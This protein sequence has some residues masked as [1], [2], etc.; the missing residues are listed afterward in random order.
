MNVLFSSRTDYALLLPKLKSE[1]YDSYHV[2]VNK[3][4]KQIVE[5]LG[6]QVLACFEEEFDQL[7]EAII[8]SSFLQSSYYGD[9]ALWVLDI[10]ER[11][12]VLAKTIAF[13]RKIFNT[14][15]FDLVVHE[16]IAIEF[17]EIMYLI[18][19]ENNVKV[20]SFLSSPF[21]GT[22]FWKESSYHCAFSK[23]YLSQIEIKPAAKDIVLNF[24][25]SVKQK[26]VNPEYLRN[27]LKRNK[28]GLLK[29]GLSLLKLSIKN[30]LG[31]MKNYTHEEIKH[32]AIFNHGHAGKHADHY[33][34]L[35]DRYH[36]SKIEYDNIEKYNDCFRAF[37]PLHY[38]PEA[39]LLYFDP[40]LS[41][42]VSV[43]Q[44]LLKEMPSDAVLF[45]KEHP[46]QPG[47]LMRPE[48]IELRRRNSN[49]KYIP[50]EYDSM[51]VLSQMQILIT[52][53]GT[54]GLESLIKQI[55]VIV[56]GRIFYDEHPDV[57]NVNSFAEVG[58]ILNKKEFNTIKEEN[59]IEYLEKIY[60]IVYKG[61]PNYD[62]KYDDPDNIRDL[63]HSI[64]Q[65]LGLTI[66]ENT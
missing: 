10:Q 52:I 50:A 9:R 2:V 64:E 3:K 30:S 26:G 29:T 42:Q 28:T 66:E 43:I 7:E 5:S 20:G 22:F 23:E 8:P 1:K 39:T 4:E 35:L 37:F 48:Y 49:L 38:E 33:Q 32:D 53:C 45:V 47:Y 16:T 54:F 58:D 27:K 44:Q 65:Y 60:S 57:Y 46:Q 61:D 13:W 56:L 36:T 40:N 62:W 11:K 25:N 19:I 31:L 15:K 34:F 17:E 51:S 63:T 6:G 55:P 21:S 14:K 24:V 12:E 18:A 59:T 41:E